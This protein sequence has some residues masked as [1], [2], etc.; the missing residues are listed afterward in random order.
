MQRCGATAN[1]NTPC[2]ER[3]RLKFWTHL[4]SIRGTTLGSGAKELKN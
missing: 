1:K 2:N 4:L 3:G